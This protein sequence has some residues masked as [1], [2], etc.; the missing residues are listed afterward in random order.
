VRNEDA[1]RDCR[2][3]PF[4]TVC[5]ECVDALGSGDWPDRGCRQELPGRKTHDGGFSA[6]IN[7]R[8]R[9]R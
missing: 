7:N 6:A 1:P 9:A 3:S 4:L 2:L 8:W 5:L